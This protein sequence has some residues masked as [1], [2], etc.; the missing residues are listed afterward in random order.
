MQRLEKNPRKDLKRLDE[1][2][3]TRA[4]R[5]SLSPFRRSLT[6]AA[7]D[8]YT[9]AVTTAIQDAIRTAVPETLPYRQRL[10]FTSTF[11]AAGSSTIT[12]NGI[13]PLDLRQ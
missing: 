8:T 11:G 5:R 4:L 12:A 10:S 9:T 2:L 7:L 6:K 13:H 1:K 3:Y